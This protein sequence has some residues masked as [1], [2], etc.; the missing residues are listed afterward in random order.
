MKKNLLI[1]ITLLVLS[2][3]FYAGVWADSKISN[4][5]ETSDIQSTDLFLLVDG[6]TS[7]KITA[8]N[9]F[10]MINTPAKFETISNSGAYASDM[11]AAT[12]KAGLATIVGVGTGD[13]PQ[14]TGIE[15]GHATE[16]TLSASGGVLS[17]EGSA[18]ATVTSV[19]TD[20]TDFTE[21]TAWRIFYSDTNGDVTELALGA[22]NTFLGSDG[23]T[24]AP[25]FQTLVDD[26]IPAS[27]D[28]DK[29]GTDGTA[30]DKIEAENINIQ[31]MDITA[32][33]SIVWNAGGMIA[34]GTCTDAVEATINSGPIVHS[35]IC[36]DAA[37]SVIDGS[38]TMPDGYDGGTVTFELTHLQS[39]AET[40]IFNSDIKAMCRGVTDTVNNT[41]GDA[42]PIDDGEVTGSNGIDHTSSAAVTPNG[43]CAAGD[44][45]FW[46][47]TISADST[48]TFATHN[49]LGM[50]MEF[51]KTLGD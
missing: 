25:S 27:I 8:I 24:S 9:V 51:T 6:A 17:V 48:V 50:K 42:V 33:D 11:L 47:L 35:I 32:V 31:S 45:L 5:G 16:N 13:S 7:T 22:A 2:F 15:L 37:T 10:D 12:T 36:T 28:P 39:A 14:F 21:Q 19:P 44:T 46:K 34:S 3:G 29:I 38:V 4:L 40:L 18:L 43:T 26:D 30:N 1:L 23:A 41:W 20:L 49:I